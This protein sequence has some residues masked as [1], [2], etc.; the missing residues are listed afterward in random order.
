MNVI[1][2]L[3]PHDISISNFVLGSRPTTVTAWGSRHV[4]PQ[5][6]DVAYLRL[7]YAD[8]GVRVN[9]HVSWLDPHKTRKLTVVGSQ[10][11]VVFDDMETDRKVTIYDKSVT[12]PQSTD[13]YG[14][15]VSVRFGDISIPRIANDEPLRLECQEFVDSIAAEREPRCSGREGLAVV[16]VLEAMQS[17]LDDGGRPVQLPG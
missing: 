16:E 12:R 17:S 8:L 10:K 11:M 6:E 13:S 3:A 7:D 9:I 14:E 4:H 15:Y 1:L 5:H 2:D